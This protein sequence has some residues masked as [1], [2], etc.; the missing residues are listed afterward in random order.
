MLED[1]YHAFVNT[2][3]TMP[4]SSYVLSASALYILKVKTNIVI[5]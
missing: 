4:E 3:L 5:M 2:P 1:L